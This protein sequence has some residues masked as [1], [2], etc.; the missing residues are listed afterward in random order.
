MENFYEPEFGAEI[1][2]DYHL[3]TEE[4]GLLPKLKKGLGFEKLFAFNF[5]ECII[6]VD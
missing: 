5:Y 4:D 3:R 6:A 2:G 1:S